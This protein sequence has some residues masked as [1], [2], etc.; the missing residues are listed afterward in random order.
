MFKQLLRYKKCN[1]SNLQL[2]V[3]KN[4]EVL[5]YDKK[6]YLWP[7]KTK[8]NPFLEECSGDRTLTRKTYKTL[9]L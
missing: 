7:R 1:L 5:N 3:N 4:R 8:F 2:N 6:Q 9:K